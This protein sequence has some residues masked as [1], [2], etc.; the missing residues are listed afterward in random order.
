MKVLTVRNFQNMLLVLTYLFIQLQK[1]PPLQARFLPSKTQLNQVV[2]FVDERSIT[3][4]YFIFFFLD[5]WLSQ[6]WENATSTDSSRFSNTK[7]SLK[8]VK[9]V[10]WKSKSKK[11]M[12]TEK[13]SYET[14]FVFSYGS[15]T[16][17]SRNSGSSHFFS[18]NNQSNFSPQLPVCFFVDGLNEK[19]YSCGG[20]AWKVFLAETR[21]IFPT[22][23]KPI[24]CCLRRTTPVFRL[25]NLRNNSFASS[26]EAF[27]QNLYACRV[28]L[29]GRLIRFQ[30]CKKVWAFQIIR[31][32]N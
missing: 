25:K 29:E 11:V 21:I 30:P 26:L 6:N 8:T 22:V 3:K 23:R 10:S 7:F 4:R 27:V 16:W 2:F 32:L 19:L 20:L 28:R 1:S 24:N 18:E 9:F 14:S 17:H 13:L 15:K 12:L 5:P 31:E